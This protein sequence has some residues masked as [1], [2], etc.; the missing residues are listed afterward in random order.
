MPDTVRH[1]R[2]LRVYKLALEAAMRIFRH[3]KHWPAHETYSLTGQIRR[4]SRSVC[5]NVAEAWRKRRYTPH[6]VSKLSDA[7]AEAAETQAWLDCARLSGYLTPD[8]F[9]ALNEVYETISG[10][11]VRMMAEPEKWCGP[12][13]LVRE[14]KVEYEV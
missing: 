11:L 9:K 5:A 13:N 12:A 4:S 3:S 8:E 1:F 6:F 2:D 14:E 10:G 7:D